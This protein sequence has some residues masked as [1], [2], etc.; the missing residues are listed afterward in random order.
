MQC[1][2]NMYS[3]HPAY[4]YGYLKY[5]HHDNASV[6]FNT[7]DDT[8]INPIESCTS[9]KIICDSRAKYP[10]LLPEKPFLII[11]SSPVINLI[12]IATLCGII[13]FIEYVIR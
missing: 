3:K 10:P 13:F 9:G 8:T 11:M 6:T 4:Q 1:L 5:I 12:S 2:Q 7:H